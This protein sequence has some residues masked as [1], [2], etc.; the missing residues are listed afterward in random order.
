M[1]AYSS[2]HEL[3]HKGY[4]SPVV[5]HIQIRHGMHV[6]LRLYVVLIHT[7]GAVPSS[8]AIHLYHQG[9]TN[10][11]ASGVRCGGDVDLI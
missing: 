4:I 2:L 6:L 5:T 7:R 11:P 9:T 10:T 3:R 8:F 1:Q